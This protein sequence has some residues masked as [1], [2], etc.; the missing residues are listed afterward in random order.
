MVFS[1]GIHTKFH[2]KGY[3]C[4][5]ISLQKSDVCDDFSQLCPQSYY[6]G[7]LGKSQ[8]VNWEVERTGSRGRKEIIE[9]N[10]ETVFALT[11]VSAL[12][13]ETLE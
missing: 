7:L 13:N 5:L 2:G 4:I 12:N 3:L 1:D 6:L 10:I 8:M 9:K 11:V